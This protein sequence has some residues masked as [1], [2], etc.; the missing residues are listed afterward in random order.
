MRTSHAALPRL[1]DP[2]N[3]SVTLRTMQ[4][5]GAILGKQLRRELVDVP[6]TGDAVERMSL[7]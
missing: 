7:A 4:R 5:A 6:T 3:A 1:L 2:E